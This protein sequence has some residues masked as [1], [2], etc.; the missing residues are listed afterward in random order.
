MWRATFKNG[1]ALNQY[2]EGK[3]I[4]FRKVLDHIKD[5]KSLSIV[6]KTFTLSVSL[7]DSHFSLL[8]D[9]VVVDFFAHDIDPQSLKNIRPIYFIRE[10]CGVPINGAKKTEVKTQ[11]IA[12]GFQA[13]LNGKNV[14]HILYIKPNGH[15]EVKM[16]QNK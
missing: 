10:G 5:L 3:E 9:G 14:K 8:K 16:E 7:I 12:L 4:L 6:L 13:N 15:P 11:F 2:N 1:S